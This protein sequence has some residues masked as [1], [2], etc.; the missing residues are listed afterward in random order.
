MK[1]LWARD[2]TLRLVR[3]RTNDGNE[4]P[5]KGLPYSCRTLQKGKPQNSHRGQSKSDSQPDN[6][7]RGDAGVIGG[8]TGN[9]TGLSLDLR[10]LGQRQNGGRDGPVELIVAES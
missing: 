1:L 8:R 9:I 4:P 6:Q 5:S 3:F 2:K 10:E 7:R